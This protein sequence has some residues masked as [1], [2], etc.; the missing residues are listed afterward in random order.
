[1]PAPILNSSAASPPALAQPL[2]PK[3]FHAQLLHRLGSPAAV[4]SLANAIL[5][6]SDSIALRAH[7]LSTLTEL[8]PPTARLTASQRAIVNTILAAHRTTLRRHSLGRGGVNGGLNP[9]F[10][11]GGPRSVQLSARFVF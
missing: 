5:D 11:I 1:M 3:L 8:F 2:R 6:D 4:E 7:A 9:L 10:Q